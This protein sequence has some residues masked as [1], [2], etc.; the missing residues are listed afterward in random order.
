LFYSTAATRV[1]L[2]KKSGYN[3]VQLSSK[4]PKSSLSRLADFFHQKLPGYGLLSA[5]KL[6][7]LSHLAVF[8][9]Q[10]GL[11]LFSHCKF[12][13]FPTAKQSGRKP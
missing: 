1:R 8:F 9:C 6:R 13:I 4:V 12:D 7:T 2:K 3:S 11:V 5:V 10:W